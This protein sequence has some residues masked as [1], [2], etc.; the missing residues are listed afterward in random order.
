MKK[1][2]LAMMT[3]VAIITAG[4]SS[5]GTAPAE[6]EYLKMAQGGIDV[7]IGRDRDDRDRRNRRDGDSGVNIG[8]GPGGVVVGPKRR[9]RTVT[10]TVEREDGRR[11]SRTE[12]R[13]D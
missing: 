8:V 13:C 5:V 7:Q 12:R 3:T 10:T 9:C 6:A 4:P 2:A 1:I 11:V